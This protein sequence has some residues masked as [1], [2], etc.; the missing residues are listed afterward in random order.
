[1]LLKILSTRYSP[2]IKWLGYC[3]A[4]AERE[5]YLFRGVFIQWKF[6]HRS[7]HLVNRLNDFEHL[8]IC[9]GTVSV[10]IVQ[11]ERP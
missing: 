4:R 2:G 8:I 11:L 10:N 7:S 6:D 9:D 5:T 3:G 1:M